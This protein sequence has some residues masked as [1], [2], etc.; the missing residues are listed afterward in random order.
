MAT[1]RVECAII[2]KSLM[3]VGLT[4]ILSIYDIGI[5]DDGCRENRAVNTFMSVFITLVCQ[6]HSKVA[7]KSLSVIGSQ[8]HNGDQATQRPNGSIC[9]YLFGDF[10]KI[11]KLFM[12]SLYSQMGCVDSCRISYIPFG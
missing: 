6:Q 7:T 9:G 8:Y 1:E 10:A 5:N 3:N 11:V 12:A 2:M 4:F